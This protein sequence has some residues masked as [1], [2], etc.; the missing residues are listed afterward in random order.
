VIDEILAA[1]RDRATLRADVLTMRA[2]IDAAKPGHGFWDVK[3]GRGGLVDLEFM[4]HFLQ[5][6]DHAAVTPDLRAAIGELVER[7]DLSPELL[8][9]H[10]LLTRLLVMLRLVLPDTGAAARVL[11]AQPA[12]VKALLAQA[13]QQADFAALEAAVTASKRDIVSAWET[14]FGQRR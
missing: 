14:L 11:A 12:T 5:L 2:D 10:D 1:P 13:T 4:T 9:A 7:G 8:A 3:L 6:R